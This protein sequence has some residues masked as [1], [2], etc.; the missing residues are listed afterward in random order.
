MD[1]YLYDDLDL[2]TDEIRVAR[3]MSADE[4]TIWISIQT[5]RLSDAPRFFALS[6]EWGSPEN[7]KEIVVD[8]RSASIRQNLWQGLHALWN[9]QQANSDDVAFWA[10]ALCIDQK[11]DFERTQQVNMMSE[12]YAAA[13]MVVVW[14][15]PVADN[16]DKAIDIISNPK[17]NWNRKDYDP[18]YKEIRSA[19]GDYLDIEFP[20][21]QAVRMDGQAERA[22]M[23]LLE[24]PYW[25]RLWIVQEICMAQEVAVLCGEKVLP[26]RSLGA[27]VEL[28]IRASNSRYT[29]AEA[30]ELRQ[31]HACD[32]IA[33]KDLKEVPQLSL[34]LVILRFGQQECTDVRDK[35]FGCLGLVDFQ[36]MP[37]FTADYSLSPRE[38]GLV[39]SEHLRL[40]TAPGLYES[41]NRISWRNLGLKWSE[42]PTLDNLRQGPRSCLRRLA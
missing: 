31:A 21:Q 8:N 1:S 5:C 38:V 19:N 27:F 11:N 32:I 9:Y 3:L 26:W 2:T 13:I 36:S 39:V 35:I 18:S 33:A 22:V 37:P 4:E 40:A 28:L 14:L 20:I 12:I 24:R 17:A 10:D 30:R 16:S 15:G 23:A 42:F 29:S 6:Y 41:V 25:R 34:E 7:L